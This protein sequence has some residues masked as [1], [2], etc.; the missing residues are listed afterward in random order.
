MTTYKERFEIQADFCKSM[1]HPVRLEIIDRLKRRPHPV[2]E[3][4]DA[5]GIGQANLSQHLAVLR[6]RGVVR[7]DR[8]G[9]VVVYSLANPKIVQ[10]CSL[11][12][13]IL[14]ENLDRQAGI[15][16]PP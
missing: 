14:G 7:A 1:A 9:I 12:R 11:I 2:H 15:I 10:A 6:S 4:S 8:R 16:V 13:E 5:I 3:L